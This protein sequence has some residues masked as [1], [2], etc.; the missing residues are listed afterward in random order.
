MKIEE[1]DYTRIDYMTYIRTYTGECSRQQR[2]I[3]YQDKYTRHIQRQRQA[4]I[5]QRVFKLSL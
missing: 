5:Y 2:T 3:H 1:K 4:N